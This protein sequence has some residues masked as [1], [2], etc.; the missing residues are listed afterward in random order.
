MM[1]RFLPKVTLSAKEI[2]LGARDSKIVLEVSKAAQL[3][4]HCPCGGPA[5]GLWPFLDVS[6][7]WTANYL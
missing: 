3:L 1:K 2:T 5:L 7:L 4:W 6:F